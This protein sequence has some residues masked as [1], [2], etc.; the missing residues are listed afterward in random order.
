M[1]GEGC[2]AILPQTQ[3]SSASAAGFIQ[4]NLE[5]LA[6]RLESLHDSYFIRPA[7]E[8]LF[9]NWIDELTGMAH[10]LVDYDLEEQEHLGPRIAGDLM[11]LKTGI[12]ATE[13]AQGA[14]SGGIQ[15]VLDACFSRVLA[16]STKTDIL[17]V[18]SPDEAKI[19]RCAAWL[20]SDELAFILFLSPVL[21]YDRIPLLPRVVHEAAHAEASISPLV[22]DNRIR[23]RWLGEVLCDVIACLLAGPAFLVS[24]NEIMTAIGMVAATTPDQRHPSFAARKAILESISGSI[25]SHRLGA[26]LVQRILHRAIGFLS[27]SEE[28]LEHRS[29]SRQVLEMLPK[30]VQLMAPPGTWEAIYL[31]RTIT[32]DSSILFQ[33]N[34]DLATQGAV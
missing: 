33:M 7:R 6:R 22:R 29:L 34:I 24:G 20:E 19:L 13:R 16:A 10:R 8:R 5:P 31:D 15:R 28:V 25:W 30:Y 17:I 27:G 21:Q 26:E 9:S 23:V 18:H 11:R 14:A 1:R 4:A 3:A 12:A 2:P 32:E